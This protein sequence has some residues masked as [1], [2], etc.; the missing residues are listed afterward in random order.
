MIDRIIKM[1]FLTV[2][3]VLCGRNVM[4]DIFYDAYSCFIIKMLNSF[5]HLH[6]ICILVV[7]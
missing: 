4:V 3:A 5:F 2:Q 1:M 6:E 7:F